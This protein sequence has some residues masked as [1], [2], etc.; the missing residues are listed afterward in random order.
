MNMKYLCM[1]AL[2]CAVGF[3]QLR[4]AAE[5]VDRIVATVDNEA[6]LLSS[7]LLEVQP[8]LAELHEMA[9]R[10]G[11]T[12][13]EYN[14]REKDVI[15]ASI[16]QNIEMNILYRQAV[17]LGYQVDDEGIEEGIE[18]ERARFESNDAFMDWLDEIGESLADIRARERKRLLA[19]RLRSDE[20]T[21]LRAEV[22]ISEADVNDYYREHADDYRF[23][24]LVSVRQIF[25]SASNAGEAARARAQLDNIREELDAGADF[26]ELAEAHSELFPDSGGSTGR[27]GLDSFVPELSAVIADLDE[28]EVSEVVET[29]YGL[30]LLKLDERQEA[31][32]L[33]LEDERINIEPILRDR[34]A[35]K[36]YAKWL[37]DLRRGSRVRVFL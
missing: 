30:Q 31:G 3:V 12:Q 6:I 25:L 1:A 21:K 28:G 18:R 9:T 33:S 11:L 17:L 22:V 7:I 15:R 34:A 37:E 14:R 16:S 10:E 35:Q 32:L 23:E 2:V 13:E 24:V 36:R 5:I 26:S 29:Q 8:A 27:K 4:S 19:L 20:L